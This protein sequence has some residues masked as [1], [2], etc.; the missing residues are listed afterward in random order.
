MNV[1]R[2]KFAPKIRNVFT[3]VVKARGCRRRRARRNYYPE[4]RELCGHMTMARVLN[5]RVKSSHRVMTIS[6]NSTNGP[7]MS[8]A[9]SHNR[10]A[11]LRRLAYT[12]RV[13]IFILVHDLLPCMQDLTVVTRCNVSPISRAIRGGL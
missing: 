6:K 4:S 13:G 2:L 9:L 7:C 11:H 10:D 12:S 8:R 1:S 3:Q 5:P